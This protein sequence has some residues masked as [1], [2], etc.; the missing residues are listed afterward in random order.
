MLRAAIL[1]LCLAIA[2]PA[3]AGQI[4]LTIT[5]DGLKREALLTVPDAPAPP[6]GRPLVLVLHGGG[7]TTKALVRT[8]GGRFDRLAETNGA[9]IL[10]PQAID[11]S[12][13]FGEG[14]VS[15]RDAHPR[16]DLHFLTAL[17]E[18]VT[19]KYGGNPA[20]AY[21]TG[22]SRGGQ[23]AYFLACKAPGLLAGIAPV[24]MS[25]PDFLED[26]CRAAPGLPILLIHGTADP[27]VPYTGGTITIGRQDRGTVLGVEATM[28]LFRAKNDCTARFTTRRTGKVEE[29]AW[30]RCAR[31]TV[32]YRVEGG[33]HTWPGASREL[34]RWL[35]GPVNRDISAPDEI[36]WF[37]FG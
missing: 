22:I 37:F 25:L 17:T 24:S 3:R 4:P 5:I 2:A 10:Y 27:I 26:D 20:R 16:D 35:V 6:G 1:T 36:W 19:R 12:W 21:A 33:G 32:L 8:T 30:E 13:D 18:A 29:T 28:R 23:A 31:P 34:P 11:R 9:L 7:G 15:A 14:V